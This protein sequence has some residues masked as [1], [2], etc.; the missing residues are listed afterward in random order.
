MANKKHKTIIINNFYLVHDGSKTG[1]PGLVIWKD[2]EANRYLL[3]RFDSDKPGEIPKKDRGVRHITKL[4]HAISQDVSKTNP[5]KSRSIK[6][7]KK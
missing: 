2:D 3:V 6:K 5:E 1:H 4:K 7:S